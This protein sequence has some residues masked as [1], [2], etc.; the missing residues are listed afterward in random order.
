MDVVTNTIAGL[1][2]VN[3]CAQ[4]RGAPSTT[5]TTFSLTSTVTLV[6]GAPPAAVLVTGSDGGGSTLANRDAVN[7]IALNCDQPRVLTAVGTAVVW[8]ALDSPLLPATWIVVLQ[9]R[10]PTGVSVTTGQRVLLVH[11]ATKLTLSMNTATGQLVLATVPRNAQCVGP[12]IAG[13]VSPVYFYFAPPAGVISQEW[14]IPNWLPQ[15]FPYWYT[16][17]P[18][19][20]PTWWVPG[21]DGCPPWVPG[22]RGYAPPRNPCDGFGPKPQWCPGP[23]TNPCWLPEPLRPP[24][25]HH[26]QGPCSSVTP[27]PWCPKTGMPGNDAD[28]H[29]CRASAGFVWSPEQGRCVRPW[30]P[31]PPTPNPTPGPIIPGS[32]SGPHG[33]KISAGE[34]WC[35]ELGRCCQPWDPVPNIPAHS[36]LLGPGGMQHMYGPGGKHLLG[37]GGTFDPTSGG[38]PGRNGGGIFHP[39]SGGIPGRNGG[40]IFHPTSGGIPGRNGGGIFHPPGL[41]AMGGEMY[42]RTRKTSF[43]MGSLGRLF[44]AGK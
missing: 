30:D 43:T 18:G 5:C 21:R 40:G 7:I 42:P 9:E 32:D 2:I 27:P 29:G 6:P 22:C 31:R 37:P 4:A 28:E 25:C 10:E 35:P 19:W 17:L 12:V 1:G 33:C 24:Y 3:P 11:A 8:S 14:V 16:P 38:I 39:T 23:V 44:G 15:W 13:G 34:R 20:W 26:G 36:S 41:A